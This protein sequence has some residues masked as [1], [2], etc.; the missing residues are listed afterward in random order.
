MHKTTLELIN[1]YKIERFLVYNGDFDT[2][3]NFI[4]DQRFVDGL[5][6]KKIGRYSPWT[7]DGKP[8]GV[9]GGFVEKYEKGLSFVLIRGA[10]H[11][12][13]HDKPE[14]ALQMFKD[15]IGVSKL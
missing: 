10:G 1:D 13:P 14:A 15:L 7:V 6:F 11:M 4:G 2:V 12:V 9:I 3:C 5:G 8:D